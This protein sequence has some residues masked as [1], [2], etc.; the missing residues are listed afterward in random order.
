MHSDIGDIPAFCEDEI[1]QT[2]GNTDDLLHCTVCK[3]HARG[4][5]EYPQ[6]FK[7][8]LLWER[9]KSA[10]VH[11][12]AVSEPQLSQSAAFGQESRDRFVP[13][14]SALVEVDF[15]NVRAVLR[16]GNNSLVCKLAA[17]VEFD[18]QR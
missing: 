8:S 14:V 18:L 13:D 7:D 6:V 10:V 2:R 5:V 16:K 12:V 3:A 9:Q 1:P 17:V 11:E 15:K 4:E